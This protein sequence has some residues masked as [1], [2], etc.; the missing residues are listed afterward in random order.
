MLNRLRKIHCM[1][2]VHSASSNYNYQET[3]SNNSNYR[4][5]NTNQELLRNTLLN[6]F[7]QYFNQNDASMN[8]E[9]DFYYLR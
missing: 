7:S 8:I 2:R 9:I 5:I 4:G 6:G 3:S 1:L